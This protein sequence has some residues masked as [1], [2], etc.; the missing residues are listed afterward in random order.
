MTQ[1]TGLPT[2]LQIA[3]RMCRLI[4]IFTPTIQSL[5]PGNQPLLAAL[6]AANAA[7]NELS[8]EIEVTIPPGV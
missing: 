3:R 1:R 5:Y 7:C 8:M 4:A 6:A 2:L